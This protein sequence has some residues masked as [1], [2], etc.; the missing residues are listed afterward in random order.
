MI[1]AGLSSSGTISGSLLIV[2]ATLRLQQPVASCT[3]VD[4]TIGSEQ[5]KAALKMSYEYL[6]LYTNAFA[7]QARITQAR[8]TQP[9]GDAQAQRDH[10]RNAFSSVASM[11]DSRFI[12]SSIEAAV[13]CLNLINDLPD[14]D[15][16][17][18]YMPLRYYL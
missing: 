14:P 6:R 1:F 15:N 7:F 4:R 10:L 8:A 13:S 11:Q 12:Y 3:G 2:S 5:L 16:D 17:L 9:Q 18:H